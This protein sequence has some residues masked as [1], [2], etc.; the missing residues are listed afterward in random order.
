MPNCAGGILA[1]GK[2]SRMGTDKAA[3]ML[4]GHSLMAHMGLVLARA[5]ISDQFFSHPEHIADEIKGF[6]PLS[7]VHAILKKLNS[8]ND[9]NRFKH[10]I[11]IPV[12]MPAISDFV[13]RRLQSAP[14]D[15]ALVTMGNYRM[16]F[17]LSTDTQWQTLAKY[18]LTHSDD[19]SLKTFY[20]NI[21]RRLSLPIS[22]NE[23]TLFRNINTPDDWHAYQTRS[24]H[25]SLLP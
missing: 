2:S 8:Q 25:D 22:E 1:G 7:G 3:L 10:I 5:G 19:V 12:D 11:I 23:K 4:S 20:K 17:R 6:G 13:I 14:N 15:M 24:D 16:P 21:P 9:N 18:L